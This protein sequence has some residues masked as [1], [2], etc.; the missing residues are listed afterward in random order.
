MVYEQSN[1]STKQTQHQDVP[2]D[3]NTAHLLCFQVVNLSQFLWQGTSWNISQSFSVSEFGRSGLKPHSYNLHLVILVQ[4]S[5][6]NISN[7]QQ[8]VS[9]L[10]A[11]PSINVHQISKIYEDSFLQKEVDM[12]PM[13]LKSS[14]HC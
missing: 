6:Y 5:S 4:F 11:F 2:L 1:R 9:L 13:T 3:F 12:T 10:T 14:D 7:Q 8:L